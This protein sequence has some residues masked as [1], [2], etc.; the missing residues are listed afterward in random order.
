MCQVLTPISRGPRGEGNDVIELTQ[1][2]KQCRGR[3]GAAESGEEEVKKCR[4]LGKRVSELTPES[5]ARLLWINHTATDKVLAKNIDKMRRGIGGG[6]PTDAEEEEDDEAA[7]EVRVRELLKK[8]KTDL[9]RAYVDL[10]HADEDADS[11]AD[12]QDYRTT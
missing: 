2:I 9:I 6:R 8:G 10:M 5:H 11:E 1:W 4:L 12:E 7:A 3:G